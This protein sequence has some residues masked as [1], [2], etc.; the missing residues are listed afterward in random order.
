MSSVHLK[1]KQP[2]ATNTKIQYKT[3]EEILSTLRSVRAIR[4]CSTLKKS[5]Q[6]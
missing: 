6:G 4:P 5:R 3:K 2:V 1:E